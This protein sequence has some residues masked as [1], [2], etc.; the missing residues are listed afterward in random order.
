MSDKRF[1][2]IQ[3]LLALANDANDEESMSAL[4]K[5]QELMLAYGVSEEQLFDCEQS[6]FEEKVVDFVVYQGKPQKWV[7]LLA[8]VIY[9]NFRAKYYYVAGT[10]VELHFLGTKSDVEIADITFHFAKG[11]IAYCARTYMQR[12]E[13]KRKRK[14][15]WQLKQDYIQGYLAGLQEQFWEQVKTNGYELA[16]QVPEYVQKEFNELSLVPGKDISQKIKDLGAF[17]EGLRE[18]K[19]LRQKERLEYQ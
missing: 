17:Q 4:A 5:A 19:Q 6:S 8:G 3:K 9:W 1:M 13:I 7:Y 2:K 15:K 12:P 18:G 16:L 11:S 10:P 14:R